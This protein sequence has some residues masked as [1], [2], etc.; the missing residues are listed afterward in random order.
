MLDK[1]A[2]LASYARLD[3]RE[4]IKRLSSSDSGLT[5]QEAIQRLQTYGFNVLVPIKKS[6]WLIELLSEFKNPL[7]L[8]LLFASVVSF[9][10]K[11]ILNGVIITVI[12]LF[13]TVLNFF[14]EYHANK[15]AEK[16]KDKVATKV[17]VIRGGKEDEISTAHLCIGDIISLRAGDV[18]PADVRLI[19]AKDFFVNQSVLTGESFP[20]EKW[21]DTTQAAQDDY[22]T[23]TN[24]AFSG[25][26]VITGTAR[27]IVVKT[28]SGTEFGKVAE[29]LT[30]ITGQS[31]FTSGIRSFSLLIMR[32][33][34]FFVLFIFFFYTFFKH[35]NVFETFTFAIAIAVGLTPELLPMIMSITMA[36][37]SLK[38]A[39]KGV[40][41][42][43]LASIPDFG[44]MSILCTDKTGT[45]TENKI[46][47]VTYT[48]VSGKHSEQVLLNAYLTSFYQTGVQNPLDDAVIRYKKEGIEAFK[49][50]DEIPFDFVR[51]RMSVIVDHGSERY[52]IAKGAPEEVLKQCT[53]YQ[54][55]S[56]LKKMETGTEKTII[57]Q[58]HDMSNDGYRVLAVAR[59]LL[60][61]KKAV[62]TKHEETDLAFLG[63]VAFLDPAK[64]DVKVVLADLEKIGIEVKVIT[65]DNE[66][67]T[68]KICHEVNLPIKSVLLGSDIEKMSDD[69][70]RAAALKTTIFARCSPNDKSRIITALKVG[71]QV[72]GYLGDGINDA[73][74]LK[75]A[76]VGISVNNA[77]DVA[78]ESADMILTHK[79]LQEL[80][81]GVLEGR[82]TFG[83][84][85]KYILM[86]ISSN[87]GNM[88]SVLG[89]ALFLPF[90]PMLP[91][92]ILLNNLLYDV[93]QISIPTDNV[94]K[95]YIQKPHKWN[96]NYIKH[97]MMIFGPISSVFDFLTFFALYSIFHVTA[98]AFHTGWFIESLATQTLIIHIIRTRRTPFIQSTASAYLILTT[99]L[100]VFIGWILPYTFLSNYLG[101]EALPF[102][103][104][105]SILA[106]V[107][108]Y[109]ICVEAGKR[110][111]YRFYSI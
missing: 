45:L 94:D 63:F 17:T 35:G 29:K 31:E 33:T 92:Q 9:L 14:Q 110:V 64:K 46:E 6:H 82:K 103:I 37:G 54:S 107:V 109:M 15:A 58:Y 83:N 49:K 102:N 85:M 25:S 95:E 51:R 74:S 76:D 80:Q 90:L 42:K 19:E 26:S 1:E 70:L 10:L 41:V 36:K 72:V 50:V 34:I 7:V 81:N 43:K 75:T 32:T 53:H 73:T 24:V 59:K 71:K 108:V 13:S 86:G 68:Q 84:T 48:D 100:V 98:A 56:E 111:F 66:L 40:I 78:K 23:L 89:A 22:S 16:L 3:A 12:I 93:S 79:S 21:P 27:A 61:E 62:Y 8:I 106:I 105:L 4:V 18:V 60:H 44:E 77:V 69:A 28:G 91:I 47:L 65:G 39:Q 88:F 20:V 2:S 96:L 30:D 57:K 101:F 55:G 67:V 87:F 38:M 52:L 99:L 5:A 104:V 11:E 97:F